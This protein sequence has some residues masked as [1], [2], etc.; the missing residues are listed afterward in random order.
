MTA[1]STLSQPTRKEA[2]GKPPK[3]Y[4]GFPL[5]AHA[6]GSW[7][8]KIR[9][10]IHY[11][12]KW[13]VVRNGKLEWL[14]YEPSW[15][16]ALADYEQK[17]DAL[18]SGRTP[19]ISGNGLT[20][21]E[22]CNR[23]LTTK[24]HFLSTGE[25][26]ARTFGDYRG[27]TDRLI[28]ILGA[29][30]MVD[31]LA[32]DDFEAIRVDIA[33]TRGPVA[34]GNEIQRVRT[35]FKL[36]Y[37][38]GLIE[39]PMR[40]GQ[41]FKKP[42]RKVLRKAKAAKGAKLFEATAI[43]SMLDMASPTLR[44]MILLGI[45]CGFGNADC[46]TLPTQAVGLDTGWIEYNRPKT[47]IARRCPLWPETV[48]ALRSAIA[49]RPSPKDSAHAE[50]LFVTKYG[51][52]WAKDTADSPVCKETGK[53]LNALGLHKPGLGFYALRH[54]FRTVADATR[55]FPAIDL[56]MGHADHT[57][58]GNYRES[59]GDDRLKA[60]TDHVRRWLFA[61][62]DKLGNSKPRPAAKPR[63]GKRRPRAVKPALR[64]VG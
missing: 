4:D 17:R 19:R 37:D 27:A 7:C 47:G 18:Y 42:S 24:A 60:V 16:A 8:K 38:N 15:Q 64:V 58:G 56:I 30:R 53:L 1:Q 46:G 62:A 2:D 21:R 34:L 50:L 23:F 6:S 40:Y 43:R 49:N 12:G 10:K 11:F 9:G 26:T 63:A 33:R 52:A 3:P 36:A 32:A 29:G 61:D 28:H 20:V 51:D 25:I 31:D 35:I 13:G 14:P 55:D 44:A 5:G 57:M 48:A 39:K 22:L 54:V 41:G 59:I 45:N